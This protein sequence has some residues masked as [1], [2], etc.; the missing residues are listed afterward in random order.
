[1]EE[2]KLNLIHIGLPKTGS[3]ALQNYWSTHKHL[4]CC[5]QNLAPMVS[6]IRQAIHQFKD[7]EDLPIATPLTFDKRVDEPVSGIYTSEALS[8]FAWGYSVSAEQV[9]KARWFFADSI[10]NQIP[11]AKVLAVIRDP[12]DWILSIYKQYIQ[13]GGHLDLQ[14]F[15]ESEKEFLLATLNLRELFDVWAEY[16]QSQDIIFLPYEMLRK[17]PQRYNQILSVKLGLSEEHRLVG[18]LPEANTSISNKEVELMR[19]SAAWFQQ[20]EEHSEWSK[21]T[22]KRLRKDL[23]L[24]LRTEF[25]KQGTLSEYIEATYSQSEPKFELTSEYLDMLE[26]QFLSFLNEYSPEFYGYLSRYRSTLY[27]NQ[28]ELNEE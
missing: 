16:Y 2:A 21:L 27:Q 14:S 19:Q 6:N 5:W 17:T 10:F 11:E 3:T 7:Y 15:V 23:L 25:Q 18:N 12:I 1:M 22:F 4:N 26:T 20:L 24:A 13:E 9:T 28:Y 8:T